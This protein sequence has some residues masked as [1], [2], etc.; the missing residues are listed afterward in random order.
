MVGNKLRGQ[1][2]RGG[3]AP[4]AAVATVPGTDDP[5]KTDGLSDNVTQDQPRAA[6]ARQNKQADKGGKKKP[7]YDGSMPCPACKGSHAHTD[8]T[9]TCPHC[10]WGPRPPCNG[11]R[12]GADS[13]LVTQGKEPTAGDPECRH[14][15]HPR[16]LERVK[17]A[18][19]QYK[20]SGKVDNALLAASAALLPGTSQA[21]ATLTL[22]G[23][24]QAASSMTV[25][26]HGIYWPNCSIDK[27]YEACSA[28]SPP[29]DAHGIHP[30][31]DQYGVHHPS[32]TLESLYEEGGAALRVEEHTTSDEH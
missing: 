2:D 4:T 1:T 18:R 21:S 32:F 20:A 22:D 9:A 8:C 10:S 6:F 5:R 27:C 24:S 23:K 25:D 15:R 26:E 7:A 3:A 11:A 30:T 14:L 12:P 19:A 13:C 28:K 31:V 17:A 16:V 29:P